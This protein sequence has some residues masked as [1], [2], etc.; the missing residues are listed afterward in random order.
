M[1]RDCKY[2]TWLPD[3][4]EGTLDAA[5]TDTLEDHMAGC[6]ACLETVTLLMVLGRRAESQGLDPVPPELTLSAL[7]SV[8][9][10]AKQHGKP[11][12]RLGMK[13][14]DMGH[15]ALT[16]L[17]TLFQGPWQFS[18]ARGPETGENG[19]IV[20]VKRFFMGLAVEIEIEKT[21]SRT[22]LLRILLPDSSPTWG[23]ARVTLKR[24]RREIGSYPLSEG[25]VVIEDIEFGRY[26]LLFSRNGTEMGRYHFEIRETLHE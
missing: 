4:I 10:R 15:L 16:S 25:Y 11:L 14:Q 22:A 23:N 21:G 20:R 18:P 5:V 1:K 24:G 9:A 26:H 2:E 6:A 12:R 7:A 3:Y 8:S 19:E 17:R 13:A